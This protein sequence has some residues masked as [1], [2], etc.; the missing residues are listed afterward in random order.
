[1]SLQL[2][3]LRH[4]S[5]PGRGGRAAAPLRPTAGC[6]TGDPDAEPTPANSTLTEFTLAAEGDGT[7]VAVVESGFDALD[8]DAAERAALLA[9]HTQR[10]GD[11]AGRPGRATRAGSRR[12]DERGGRRSGAG[13][14]RRARR[15]DPLA[16]ARDA[17][18]AGRGDGDDARGP[19]AGQPAGGDQA[20]RRARQGGAGDAPAG[21]ARGPLS[22]RAGAARGDGAADRRGG[23]RLGSPGWPPS[24]RSR[25]KGRRRTTRRPRARVTCP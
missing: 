17:R 5:R 11:G 6:R 7:R 21:R 12:D 3:R 9:S 2:A 4:R 8:V 19:A 13:G 1:M 22:R 23:R 20:P 18:P 25:K 24:R 15:P 16:A 10:L 14:L